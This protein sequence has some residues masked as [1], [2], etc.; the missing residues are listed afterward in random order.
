MMVVELSTI[1]FALIS[2]RL[3][4]KNWKAWQL[5]VFLIFSVAWYFGLRAIIY[6][7]V[8]ILV[9]LFFAAALLCLNKDWDW[10]A[11]IILACATMKPQV[12]MFPI[13]CVLI[14]AFFARR[15]KAVLAFFAT[16]AFFVA[17]GLFL[18]PTWL[19]DDWREV[20]RYPSY[21]PPGNPESSLRAIFGTPGSWAGIAISLGALALLLILWTRLPKAKWETFLGIFIITLILSPL[22]GLQTDAGNEYILMLPVALL[23]VSS[24]EGWIGPRSRF[25]LVLSILFFGLWGLFLATVQRSNQ[26]VQHPILLFPLPV[27]LL[28]IMGWDWI[29]KRVRPK[30]A[31]G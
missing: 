7:N 28:L 6:G 8:V 19:A 30:I 31:A 23:L 9:S 20:L 12:A 24:Q 5:V 17:V 14:W 13:A 11:G 26:P 3:S 15:Y 4:G 10:A 2:T 16:L 27:F 18:L 21:N 1:G 25:V 29:Q 22:S